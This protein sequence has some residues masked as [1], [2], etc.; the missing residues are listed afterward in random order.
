M[1]IM[2]LTDQELRDHLSKGYLVPIH[3]SAAAAI[4]EGG[5][6]NFTNPKRQL[7]AHLAR[8]SH[9]ELP[10]DLVWC[11][12]HDHIKA[13]RIMVED[14]QGGLEAYSR[15]LLCIGFLERIKGVPEFVSD[16][17]VESFVLEL[18]QR[19][20]PGKQV[21]SRTKVCELFPADRSFIVKAIGQPIEQ[22]FGLQ[23]LG[24]AG[25]LP[26]HDYLFLDADAERR[27]AEKYPEERVCCESFLLQD[28]VSMVYDLLRISQDLPI[29]LPRT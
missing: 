17:A 18:F 2:S 6:F 9:T 10:D 19:L 13:A 5:V 1:L 29:Y 26:Q 16:K 14:K 28:F 25:G 11:E 3:Y 12:S 21:D 20:F 23:D 22:K 7:F 8:G 27:F 4:E 24:F 15:M